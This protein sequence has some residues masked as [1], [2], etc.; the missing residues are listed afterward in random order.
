MNTDSM[1]LFFETKS[2]YFQNKIEELIFPMHAPVS[3]FQGK[4]ELSIFDIHIKTIYENVKLPIPFSGQVQIVNYNPHIDKNLDSIKFSDDADTILISNANSLYEILYLSLKNEDGLFWVEKFKYIGHGKLLILISEHENDF[5]RWNEP[6]NNALIK[7]GYKL[8]SISNKE[9]IF[10]K[11]NF[12]FIFETF[13]Y[14]PTLMI[15]LTYQHENLIPLKETAVRNELLKFTPE[16]S[17]WNCIPAKFNEKSFSLIS[18]NDFDSIQ[19]D[20]KVVDRFNGDYLAAQALKF[21]YS[22]RKS[23]QYSSD[24]SSIDKLILEVNEIDRLVDDN[25]N[26][27][28]VENQND[29]KLDKTPYGFKGFKFQIIKLK[30]KETGEIIG[31]IILWN[32]KLI[33]SII[34]IE[35]SI[36]KTSNN[37]ISNI[38]FE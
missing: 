16:L 22:Q 6:L 14:E 4:N 32:F 12:V 20:Y 9:I 35:Y 26:Y 2:N 13:S 24:L 5:L 38:P 23:V 29:I 34:T 1:D 10:K 37:L 3:I 28:E 11:D 17:N 19:K 36:Q 33:K 21:L 7:E 8:D 31:N 25:I 15:T 18:Y 30:H 27:I